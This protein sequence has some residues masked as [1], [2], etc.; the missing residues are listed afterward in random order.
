MRG[1]YIHIPFCKQ[2]CRY[3]DFF[4]TVSLKHMD[5][6]V[7]ALVEEIRIKGAIHGSRNLQSLYFGGGTPSLLSIKQLE[8]LLNEIHRQFSFEADAE[9]S[10][11][12]NPDDLVGK[13]AKDLHEAGFN[14]L[15]I[16]IQSFQERDLELMRRSHSAAQG[17]DAVRL[18]A[19]AGFN[20]ISLDLIYGIPGQTTEKW[21]EN[22]SRALSLPLTHLSA[23]HLT[24]EPGT[25][26]DHW[27]KKR[28]LLP[29][30]EE[31]SVEQYLILREQ[32]LS[33]GFDHYEL[34]NFGR[35]KS[36]S[37]HNM[38]Y[39]SGLPYLGLG[40]SAHSFNGEERSWNIS[41]LNAYLEGVESGGEIEV[42]EALGSR[43]K[44]HDYLITTLR[45]KQ[46][47]DPAHME[48]SFG[49]QY[50][51]HFEQQARAFIANGSMVQEQG[52]VFIEPGQ[53]LI[54]DHILRTLFMD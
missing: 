44:Y 16:G 46:G 4:F 20:D 40:P 23:Y 18:A 28:R 35:G 32:L 1:I 39:W 8:R 10:I 14:R 6:F 22:I 47:A 25:V 53:W 36:V 54:T 33:A 27:R 42:R 24:F 2:A 19:S 30:P 51:I 12:C 37:R 34:S 48:A 50:R 49:K 43:E 11:E 41:S 15:S 9:R 13:G 29:V 7:D 3:C 52:R 38:L 17:E 45:T 21:K 31:S 26:F 5:R